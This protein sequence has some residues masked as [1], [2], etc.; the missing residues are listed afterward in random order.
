MILVHC[1]QE[2]DL[3]LLLIGR[4]PR[5]AKMLDLCIA[6][7]PGMPDRRCLVNG[8]Q[9]GTS[10]VARSAVSAGR[11]DRNESRQVRVVGTKAV[12]NP[13]SDRWSDQVVAASVQHRNSLAVRL[14]AAV[15]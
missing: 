10:I 3:P 14:A 7:F 5:I 1:L 13:R 4:Q 12:R 9:K 8:W 2:F 15:H 6:E 11:A